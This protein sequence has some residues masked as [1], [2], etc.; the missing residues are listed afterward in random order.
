[1]N[2]WYLLILGESSVQLSNDGKSNE[3]ELFKWVLCNWWTGTVVRLV[4][5][6][7]SWRFWEYW[8][9]QDR[10][11]TGCRSDHC[12]K[13]RL[14]SGLQYRISPQ[15]ASGLAGFLVQVFISWRK[16]SSWSVQL[17]VRSFYSYD[18]NSCF[19]SEIWAVWIDIVAA[20]RDKKI[21]SKCYNIS[22]HGS[23]LLNL[24]VIFSKR[25]T[26]SS[27]FWKMGPRF[28]TDNQKSLSKLCRISPIGFKF[29]SYVKRV[30]NKPTRKT[31][32]G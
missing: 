12:W 29:D 10:F 17:L 14:D 24:T 25:W 18:S 5:I 21:I 9:F 6:R 4:A 2:N 13:L 8:K 15:I 19:T 28:S 11:R 20:P 7:R 32:S 23:G 27:F 3:S 1:M 22:S 26:K 16:I 30:E 31:Y